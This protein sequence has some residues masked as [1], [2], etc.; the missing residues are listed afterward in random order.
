MRSAAESEDGGC[1]IEN[2]REGGRG[3]CCHGERFF[4][5]LLIRLCCSAPLCILPPPPLSFSSVLLPA[6]QTRDLYTAWL[7]VDLSASE[8]LRH[9]PHTGM[10]DL[11]FQTQR[12]NSRR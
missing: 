7:A 12:E 11:V 8:L 5:Q 10:G 3:I 6:I 9:P 2:G 1:G 4:K